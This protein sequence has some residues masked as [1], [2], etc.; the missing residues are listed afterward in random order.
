MGAASRLVLADFPALCVVYAAY[1]EQ[2]IEAL[3]FK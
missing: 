2:V 1:P 3:K